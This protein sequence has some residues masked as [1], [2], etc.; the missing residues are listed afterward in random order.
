[1]RKMKYDLRINNKSRFK[2]KLSTTTYDFAVK[3]LIFLNKKYN[4]AISHR[5]F[6]SSLF[7]VGFSCDL[8]HIYENL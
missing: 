5:L 1:M 8:L 3:G 7:F 4:C 6:F 2:K